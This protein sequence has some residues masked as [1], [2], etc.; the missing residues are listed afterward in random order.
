MHV[1]SGSPLHTSLSN[2]GNIIPPQ[3]LGNMC[4]TL[5][6]STADWKQKILVQGNEKLTGLLALTKSH[7]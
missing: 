2:Q 3:M 4:K 7:T 6:M 5:Q 1:T